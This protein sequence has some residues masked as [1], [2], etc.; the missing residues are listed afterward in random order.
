MYGVLASFVD[1]SNTTIQIKAKPGHCCHV[2]SLSKQ[3]QLESTTCQFQVH[4][5]SLLTGRMG[6]GLL[7]G[8]VS[9]HSIPLF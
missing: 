9:R 5:F 8:F 6:P 1:P 3:I 4:F 2:L 7:K